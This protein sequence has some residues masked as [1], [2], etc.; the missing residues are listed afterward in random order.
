MQKVASLVCQAC[1]IFDK[2]LLILQFAYLVSNS[3]SKI[4]FKMTQIAV[5]KLGL[6]VIRLCKKEAACKVL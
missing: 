6:K 5:D 3:Y 4:F 1:K 2:A